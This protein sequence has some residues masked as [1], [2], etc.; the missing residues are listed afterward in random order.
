MLTLP[1]TSPNCERS[2]SKLKL[3]KDYLASEIG[4]QHSGILSAEYEIAERFHFNSATDK[5]A[6]QK[7]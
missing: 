1:V 4:Q 5:M 7:S 2:F 6:S 3:I